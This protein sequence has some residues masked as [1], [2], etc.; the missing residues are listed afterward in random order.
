MAAITLRPG[1]TGHAT[2]QGCDKF[3]LASQMP[4]RGSPTTVSGSASEHPHSLE[5]DRHWVD[6]DRFRSN[7]R[8]GAA[9]TQHSLDEVVRRNLDAAA[10]GA[11]G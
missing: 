9:G 10:L 5:L 11:E 3:V 4:G 6:P 2:A 7:E 8:R 1:S